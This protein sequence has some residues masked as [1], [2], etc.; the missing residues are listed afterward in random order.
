MNAE[1]T[2]IALI[3]GALSGLLLLR[4]L[5][6]L[7]ATLFCLQGL[8]AS[9]WKRLVNKASPGQIKYS[10]I[11]NTLLRVFLFGL[12][13]AGLYATGDALVRREFWFSY[14]KH[15]MLIWAVAAGLAVIVLLRGSWRRLAM[16]WKMTH[17]FDFAEKMKRTVMLKK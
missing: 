16:V 10:V 13:F 7:L 6:S 1:S 5:E 17:H 15:D 4:I 14:H 8:L 12:L 9:R 2:I 3:W 11:L